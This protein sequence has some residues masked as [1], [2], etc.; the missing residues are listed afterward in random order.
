M[1]A[2]G[3]PGE[4][5]VR[6]PGVTP[7]YWNDPQTTAAAIRDGW[8]HSGDLGVSDEQ[9]RVTFLDRMKELIISGGINISPVEL[10]SAIG[11]LDGVA[12]VAVIA[13]PDPRFGET[14]AAIVTVAA[15]FGP[16]RVRGGRALRDRAGGLQGAA[17]RGA[18][19]AIR[20]P[21]CPAASWT[22]R[23]PRRIPRHPRPLRQGP[24]V[25]TGCSPLWA[26]P[27][28]PGRSTWCRHRLPVRTQEPTACFPAHR[29]CG[30]RDRGPERR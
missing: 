21:G 17:L 27:A 18:A 13:A 10:E 24:V 9:G 3:Q 30:R 12:E 7:G 25:R 28:A 2:P 29:A 16:R 15:R 1:A 26:T 5:V 20:C 23:H 6:G 19:L 8:L 4:L 22:K 14:P 11:A